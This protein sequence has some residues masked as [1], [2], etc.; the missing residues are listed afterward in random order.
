[1]PLKK[2]AN[3]CAGYECVV[4]QNYA[5]L[6]MLIMSTPLSLMCQ[7]GLLAQLNRIS[8]LEFEAFVEGQVGAPMR[9]LDVVAFGLYPGSADTA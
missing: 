6:Q 1:M 4:Y 7:P 3:E 2:I 5:K 8:K 9:D